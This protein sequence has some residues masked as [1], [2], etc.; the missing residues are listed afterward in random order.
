[1]THYLCEYAWLPSGVARD[2]LIAIEDGR[3]TRAE[4]AGWV[5][6]HI[7]HL[8]GLTLPGLA[9]AHSHAFHRVL[10]GRTPGKGSFWTWRDQMYAAAAKL[11]PE[12]YHRLARAVFAE[13]ALAGVTC[14]GEFHYLHHAP[15]GVRYADPNAMGEALLAAAGEAGVRITLLDTLYLQATVDGDP[16]AG[17][18]LRFGDGTFDNWYER[19]GD[20]K[21]PAH[22]RIGAALHSVRAVP[23]DAF[24]EFAEAT[25]GLPVHAHVSEQV[26]ENYACLQAHGCTPTELLDRHG[27]LGGHFTAVHATHLTPRDIDLLRGSYACFCP[28]TE[29]DLGDGIGPARALADAGAWLTLGSDSHAVIDLI[30]ETRAVELHERLVRQERGQFE[31]AELLRAATAEGHLSLGWPDAGT[32]A[33][34]QRADLVT[35]ALDTVRTAGIDPAGVLMAASAA[36][37]RH[38]VVD[39][40][41]VVADGRHTRIDVARE[42]SEAICALF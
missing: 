14:V 25:S 17:T 31:P 3:I 37:V 16:L 22:G 30:E 28:T 32:L 5:D 10:R 13:M 4:Q 12:S 36:D 9:N 26:A 27:V 19:F 20:L 11:N 21:A 40:D 33:A 38:V 7:R 41:V 24:G 39:G 8:P 34:G 2:V 23:A 35:V 1:M 42:L 18:Q 15:D 29:R 6:D